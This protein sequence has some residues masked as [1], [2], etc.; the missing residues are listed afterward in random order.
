MSVLNLATQLAV[1][2]K[3]FPYFNLKSAHNSNYRDFTWVHLTEKYTYIM[4]K[5][6]IK[7]HSQSCIYLSS[8]VLSTGL[9]TG[10]TRE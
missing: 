9:D 1:S 6:E 8:Y 2:V 3:Y 5:N 7:K 10:D 4:L